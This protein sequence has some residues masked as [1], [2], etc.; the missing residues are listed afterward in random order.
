M[1]DENESLAVIQQ[2]M[3]WFGCGC[4]ELDRRYL[5]SMAARN[6]ALVLVAQQLDLDQGNL[7]LESKPLEFRIEGFVDKNQGFQSSFSVPWW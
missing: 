1:V 7:F 4:H 6:M 5:A 3:E 2:A